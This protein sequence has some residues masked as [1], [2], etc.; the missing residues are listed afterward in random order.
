[1]RDSLRLRTYLAGFATALLA[2]H[3]AG[4][5]RWLAQPFAT[6]AGWDE[7]YIAAF[8]QRMI[9]GQWLPYV[10]AVSHRGPVLYW[11][12]AL[13][14]WLAGG[15]S[16]AAMRH[17]ALLFAEANLVLCFAVGV[18]ARR[19]L[20]GFV[21][22]A[23]FLFTTAYSME[24]KDGIAFN[25]ELVAMPFV[26][27]GTLLAIVA[28][29]ERDPG[30][31][32]RVWLTTGAGVLIML[33]ALSKQ[34]AGLHLLPI[35]AWL[36]ATAVHE[37]STLGRL[38]L[39][40]SLGF[41]VGAVTPA[42]AVA[43]YFALAGAWRPFTYYLVTYNRSVYMGPVSLG[44]ALESSFLF[45]RDNMPLLFLSLIG[46][47]WAASRFASKLDDLRPA[48]WSSALVHTAVPLTTA[49]HLLLA[50]VGAVATFRFWD[51]YFI[52]VLPWFGLLAGL[53]VESAFSEATGRLRRTHVL[54]LVC[55]VF[56]SFVLRHL[57]TLWLDGARREGRAFLDPTRDPITSYIREHTRDGESVFVWGFA[58]E[59][60]I[61]ARRR[62]VSRFV[63][64]T[65]PAGMVP[66]FPMLSLEDET[67][68]AV[69]G[70]R[71][72]LLRELERE[73]PPLIVDVPNSME[74][75]SLRRYEELRRYLDTNYCFERTL[76][77]D[78][79]R[80][81]DVYH[82]RLDDRPCRST[83]PPLP[84]PN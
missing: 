22:A 69:P 46:V 15:Y 18:A 28:L 6:W 82:R 9:E 36:I 61:S 83:P 65:F 20:A 53:L 76:F 29:R 34:P 51:H 54:V 37:R 59:L 71:A 84:K 47:T 62:P 39:R 8:A 41:V 38:D 7:A 24:P 49:M 10:D 16:W 68:L 21:A 80:I 50:I 52:P 70:A 1:M 23:T 44:Y 4:V 33:G 66:W 73:R 31:E 25:G 45:W 40:P 35:G 63:F 43:A 56:V 74:H 17:M 60:Y 57:T 81:A 13:G 2:W 78:N 26:L 12:A 42:L 79:G 48:A 5:H 75:R 14:Q 32:S 3:L 11:L 72:A 64:T 27:L 58:P 30:S 55:F 77:G 67:R 19:P